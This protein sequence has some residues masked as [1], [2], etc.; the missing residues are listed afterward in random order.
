MAADPNNLQFYLEALDFEFRDDLLDEA[1]PHPLQ[2]V[3]LPV[4]VMSGGLAYLQGT[5]FSIGS[6]LALTAHH[7]LTQDDVDTISQVALLHVVTGDGA[8]TAHATLIEVEEVTAH[9][10]STDVSV[11]R[12]KTP[13]AGEH[14]PLPLRPMRLGMA[15]PHIDE[16]IAML[17]YTHV[18]PMASLD[19]VL[20]LRPKLH[21][22]TGKVLQ[23]TPEGFGR[24]KGPCW[25]VE[26]K[27]VNQMSG[28][29]ALA[30]AGEGSRMMVV[31]GVI[32]T[33]FN[34]AE[35]D[36]PLSNAAMPYTAMALAPVVNRGSSEE[37]TFLYDLAR[38]GRIPVVDLDLIDFDVSDFAKPR[39]ALVE[40][41]PAG[42]E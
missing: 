18:D 2:S 17:G 14:N 5:A 16:T 34:V 41:R 20:M 37:P 19:E 30:S 7:V 15:A 36:L 42:E 4:I 6:N 22:T 25:Q 32:S 9:P 29:P 24:C 31:R 33:G 23:H 1:F 40:E 26:A 13:S 27:T 12:L 11:L 39:L 10:G 8:D 21:L 35:D 28:G 38:S 3:V